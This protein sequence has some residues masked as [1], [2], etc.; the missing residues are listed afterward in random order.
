MAPRFLSQWR[1]G[2]LAL[3]VLVLL[4]GGSLFLPGAG[5][6]AAADAEVRDFTIQVD[7]KPAGDYHMTIRPQDDG[8]VSLSAESE[9]H[10]AVLLVNV[11]TY[12][13]RGR[14]VWKDGRLQ[15]FESS[16][17]E[18]GK[19]FAVSA[20]LGGGELH[21]KTNGQESVLR[22]DVWTT[23]CWQLPDARLRNQ[24]VALMG[25]D[26]GQLTIGQ[27]QFVGSERLQVAGQEQ[28]CGHYRLM[29]DVPYD[30]WFDAQGRLVR[31]EWVSK[32]HKTVLELARVSR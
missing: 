8:S 3:L 5:R 6:A 28:A 9:V 25:C 1:R 4:A 10:V 20:D 15:H 32:G 11:Y 27:M 19:A 22:A 14:E 21:V 12:S 16:G 24:A 17:K 23:S 26:N 31:Q 29:R 2:R 13:Y 18:N 30:Q 7:G